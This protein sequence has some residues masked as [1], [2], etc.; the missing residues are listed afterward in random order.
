MKID[1]GFHTILFAAGVLAVQP[2]TLE[3]VPSFQFVFYSIL[4]TALLSIHLRNQALTKL[5]SKEE[6]F[7]G[8]V[9][10]VITKKEQL[11]A[12]N[13]V[14][15]EELQ[16]MKKELIWKKKA[17]TTDLYIQNRE[18]EGLEKT[19]KPKRR[20]ANS[21]IL[22]TIILKELDRCK[23]NDYEIA[24]DSNVFMKLNDD[25]CDIIKK[26]KVVIS[27][28]FEMNGTD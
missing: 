11:I 7:R 8:E 27:L 22:N 16:E 6:Y 28:S 12:L 3:V 4:V 13:Q 24:I 26:Y 14:K 5:A 25:L 10:K 1:A 15:E 17:V 19:L 9:E 20:L 23:E 21:L 2:E 18:L